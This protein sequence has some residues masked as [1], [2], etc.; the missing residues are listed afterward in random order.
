MNWFAE[1]GWLR[2]ILSG[3]LSSTVVLAVIF[4]VGRESFRALLKRELEAFKFELTSKLE[5]IK[6]ELGIEATRKQL[7][8]QSQIQFKERQLS[9]FYGPIYAHLKRIRPID[10]LLNENRIQPIDDV[11]RQVVRESNN[12]IVDIILTKSSLIQGDRI[13]ESYTHFLTHVAIWH[14][15]LD[16]P[17]GGWP[18]SSTLPEA[19]YQMEFE[20]EIYATTEALKKELYILYEQYGLS[21]TKINIRR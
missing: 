3:V 6:S 15:F 11:A 12:K 4:F 7:T 8:L 20:K 10:D 21:P 18:K 2:T 14:A 16:S 19:D 13:P 1:G 9:E 17:L 5:T